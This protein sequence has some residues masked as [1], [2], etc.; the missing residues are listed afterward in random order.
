RIA[1]DLE[2]EMLLHEGVDGARL[3]RQA[4]AAAR[5]Q[6][7]GLPS[8][9][10]L[11]DGWQTAGWTAQ[12]NSLGGDF[13]DWFSLPEGR[14]A[15][16]V[17]D[18]LNEDMEAA[19][20]AAVVRAAVRSHAQYHRDAHRLLS[21]VNLTLWT[22]SAGDQSANLFCGLVDT[23]TG[24]VRFASAG[25]VSVVLLGADGWKSLS[26]PSA[27]LGISP[28]STYQPQEYELR[29]GESLLIFSNGFRDAVDQEGRSLGESGLGD[30]L[31]P[32][33]IGM[34]ADEIVDLAR[35]RLE[36]HALRPENSDRTVMVIKRTQA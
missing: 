16:A 34:S 33:A 18:A 6:R 3:K 36:S 2:R 23:S 14:L 17:G 35:D 29:E 12:A 13:F 32:L 26:Q 28:E 31:A 30:P 25:Q 5:M 20:S 19:L 21:N 8:V 11:L 27:A 1:A 24:Q 10:P 15:I 22:G 4:E 9:S 7:G